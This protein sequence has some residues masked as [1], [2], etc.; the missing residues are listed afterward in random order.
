MITLSY[1]QMHIK[2]PSSSCNI[3]LSICLPIPD[4]HPLANEI[5]DRVQLLLPLTN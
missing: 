4:T 2:T 5:A 1:L 3:L